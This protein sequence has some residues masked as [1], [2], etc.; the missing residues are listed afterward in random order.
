M[1]KTDVSVKEILA[2]YRKEIDDL[3]KEL[4]AL[5]VKRYQIVRQVANLKGQYDIPSVLPDRVDEVRDNAARMAQEQGLNGE[6][7]RNLYTMMIDYACN[8]EDELMGHS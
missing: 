5:L 3:D 2:P 7:V 8:L 6:F 1:S 4:V